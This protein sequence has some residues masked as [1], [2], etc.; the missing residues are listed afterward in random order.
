MKAVFVACVLFVQGSLQVFADEHQPDPG[1]LDVDRFI[2][3]FDAVCGLGATMA[4]G[5]AAIRARAIV[6]AAS[7]PWSAVGRVNFASIRTRKHCTGTL[8]AENIVLTAAHCL[9]NFPRKRWIPPQSITYVAGFQR[10]TL[11][12]VSPV[13][14]FVLS[15]LEDLASRD[16]RSSPN[17]DW[18]LLVL[19]RPIGRDVGYLDVLDMPLA[20]RQQADFKLAGYSG[21]RPNVLSVASDCGL[22][23]GR[24][25]DIFLQKCSAMSGD[26]G[27]PLLVAK[28]GAYAVVGVLSSIVGQE[29]GFASLAIS[30]SVFL[31]A[32]SQ[33]QQE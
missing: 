4:D 19:E 25:A 2:P 12:A 22:P 1:S 7:E 30:S 26:S 24:S 29:A 31:D 23:R 20:D 5:C 13:R 27:A 3:N 11:R 18:A 16:F 33:A 28:D 15:D 8:V 32:L 21:L 6:D 9:Y 17:Q 10:G 14:R